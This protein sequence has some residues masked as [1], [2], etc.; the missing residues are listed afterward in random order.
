[1]QDI[2]WVNMIGCVAGGVHRIDRIEGATSYNVEDYGLAL[3]EA[4]GV[5]LTPEEF[6]IMKTHT[7]QGALLLEKVPQLRENDVYRYAYDIAR[8][9]HE[10]WDGS[11]YP[12]GLKGNEISLWAQIV[13]LADVYDALS[14]KRVYKDAYPRIQVLEMI[15][16]GAC[17]AFNP[18][19]LKCFFSV[20][21]TLSKLYRH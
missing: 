6:E 7:I 5:G 11:G 4:H 10:R 19:L 16:S 17:G 18:H 14:C 15:Q 9:H 12:D 3:A 21:G 8:H 20:E 2:Y 1:M 13:S